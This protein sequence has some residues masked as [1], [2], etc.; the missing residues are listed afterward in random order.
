LRTSGV[1]QSTPLGDTPIM[2]FGL[3]YFLVSLDFSKVNLSTIKNDI[4]FPESQSLGDIPILKFGFI[5]L[6]RETS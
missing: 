3:L 1:N 6:L 5:D 2:K 4:P